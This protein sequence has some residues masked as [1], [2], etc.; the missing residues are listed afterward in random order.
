[1]KL[2]LGLSLL[3]S[4]VAFGGASASDKAKLLK[5]EP[6]TPCGEKVAS[7]RSSAPAITPEEMKTISEAAKLAAIAKI[8]NDPKAPESWKTQFAQLESGRRLLQAE[9]YGGGGSSYGGGGGVQCPGGYNW[10]G[11]GMYCISDNLYWCNQAYETYPQMRQNCG[12]G[13]IQAP[14]G[15]A[16]YCAASGGG[17]GGGNYLSHYVAY[18]NYAVRG[19]ND[20]V[21]YDVRDPNKCAEYCHHN[22]DFYC[23]S[24]E[25]NSGTC[26]L[27]R[28]TYPADPV[29]GWT[30]YYPK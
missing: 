4:A 26:V 5:C 21:M 7:F 25:Y 19:H 22:R 9:T 18:P 16:D 8:A 17:G 20:R 27:S 15:Q 1:M 3:P 23:A 10:G 2:F 13:C 28:S 30:L 12:N 24:F 29:Y 11:V 6:D 14:P